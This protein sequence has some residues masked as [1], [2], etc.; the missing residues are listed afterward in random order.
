MVNWL[1]GGAR[2]W[3]NNVERSLLEAYLQ[4]PLSGFSRLSKRMRADQQQPTLYYPSTPSHPSDGRTYVKASR[5]F[6]ELLQL[7]NVITSKVLQ[8]HMRQDEFLMITADDWICLSCLRR[9]VERRLWIWW[10]NEKAQGR[11]AG[12]YVREDCW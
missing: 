7:P 8:E 4:A 2:L 9:L 6:S 12:Q 1:R 3:T 11:V 5:I 10:R